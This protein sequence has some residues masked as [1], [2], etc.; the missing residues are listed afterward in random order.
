MGHALLL[1]R[2]SV[3]GMVLRLSLR[4]SNFWYGPFHYEYGD[5]VAHASPDLKDV[6]AMIFRFELGKP[7]RPYE[8]LMGVLPA[9]S[10]RL[11]PFAYQ[12]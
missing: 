3:M 6:N 4:S 12:V 1:Q 7:F 5:S 11:V 8:Q 10:M 9:A 2:S